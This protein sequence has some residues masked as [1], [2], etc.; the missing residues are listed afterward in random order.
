MPVVSD[1]SEQFARVRFILSISH[2]CGLRL[3]LGQFFLPGHA[4][5]AS[6]HPFRE[7]A[8]RKSIETDKEIGAKKQS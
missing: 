8:M 2:N 3:G 4:A 1:Q 6:P 5:P 7:G